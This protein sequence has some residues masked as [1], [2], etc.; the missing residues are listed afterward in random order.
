MADAVF[1]TWSR[2]AAGP[3][4]VLHPP[5]WFILGCVFLAAWTGLQLPARFSLQF[6]SALGA[7]LLVFATGW[8]AARFGGYSGALPLAL[9]SGLALFLSTPLCRWLETGHVR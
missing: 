7:A 8:L 6:A 9:G 2:L 3:L 4:P 1:R 5:R